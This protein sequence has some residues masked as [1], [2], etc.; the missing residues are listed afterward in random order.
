MV[1]IIVFVD[2]YCP[3]GAS[4]AFQRAVSTVNFLRPL[5][6]TKV[7]LTVPGLGRARWNGRGR[8][9]HE[10]LPAESKIKFQAS[11]KTATPATPLSFKPTAG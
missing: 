2:V 4:Q 8:M 11:N 3:V 6:S 7:H 10:A 9:S 1:L 5:H